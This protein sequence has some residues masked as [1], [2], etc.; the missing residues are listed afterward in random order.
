M[1]WWKL[2]RKSEVVAMPRARA[3]SSAAQGSGPGVARCTR[4]GWLCRKRRASVP[5][6]ARPKRR[7]GY[8][9]ITQPAVR[10]SSLASRRDFAGLARPDQFD[11][12]AARAQEAYRPLDGERDPVQLRRPGFG[13]VGD[14]HSRTGMEWSE[15]QAVCPDGAA[16]VDSARARMFRESRDAAINDA[17]LSLS[18]QIDADEAQAAASAC[19]RRAG[20]AAAA[21]R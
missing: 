7:S 16:A 18:F 1:Y 20:R 14:A 12:V 6:R 11:E 13:D 8:I 21:R 5:G 19:R 4:S 15:R 10:S 3:A 2:V 9:G 17:G